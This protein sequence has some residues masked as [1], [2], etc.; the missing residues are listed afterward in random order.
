MKY[1]LNYF[2]KNNKICFNF[3]GLTDDEIAHWINMKI[4]VVQVL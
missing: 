2:S 3:L 1:S 4:S